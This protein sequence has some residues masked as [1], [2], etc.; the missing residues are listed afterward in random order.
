MES[1]AGNDEAGKADTTRGALCSL[2]TEIEDLM[3]VSVFD[4]DLVVCAL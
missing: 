3:F 4:I 1:D 2:N